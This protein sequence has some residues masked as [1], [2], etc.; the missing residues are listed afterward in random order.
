MK[1]KELIEKLKEMDQEATV[2]T[3]GGF[4]AEPCVPTPEYCDWGNP[5]HPERGVYL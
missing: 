3:W 5:E 1:V 4:D 2:Y